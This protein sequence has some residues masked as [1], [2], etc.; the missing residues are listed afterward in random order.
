MKAWDDVASY[1]SLYWTG[2]EDKPKSKWFLDRGVKIERF[3]DDGSIEIHDVMTNSDKFRKI[4]G[5][6]ME[7]F[8]KY[9]WD[10]GCLKVN[11]DYHS[12]SIEWLNHV[13][14]YSTDKKSVEKNIN[15]HEEKLSNYKKK[16]SIFVDNYQ[17]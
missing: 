9:G 12:A 3:E 8:E 10:A 1:Y 2:P 16:L 7:Y 6:Q 11:I 15:K 14:P 17:I 13:Y 5:E 4:D